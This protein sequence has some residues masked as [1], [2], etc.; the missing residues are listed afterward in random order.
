MLNVTTGFNL[1]VSVSSLRLQERRRSSVV[2]SLPGSDVSPGDLF[3]SNGAADMLND[4][5][6]GNIRHCFI[7]NAN[8]MCYANQTADLTLQFKFIDASSTSFITFINL[9]LA[10]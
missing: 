3:V 5:F 2:V 8:N 10:K 9:A 1:D 7:N 6:S 4:S